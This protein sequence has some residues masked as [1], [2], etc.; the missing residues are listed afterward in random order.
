MGARGNL[1]PHQRSSPENDSKQGSERHWWFNYSK[2]E[3]RLNEPRTTQSSRPPSIPSAHWQLERSSRVAPQRV[4]RDATDPESS[5]AGRSNND[6]T[7][8]ERR[9]R[10]ETL[11][12]FNFKVERDLRLTPKKGDKEETRKFLSLRMYACMYACMYVQKHRPNPNA[13]HRVS[14]QLGFDRGEWQ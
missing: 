10:I 14:L 13:S 7:V 3:S 11:V 1:P 8:T 2:D 12:R 5:H 4:S 9:A 6:K